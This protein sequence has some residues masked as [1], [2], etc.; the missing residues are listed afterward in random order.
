[1]TKLTSLLIGSGDS[2]LMENGKENY[3][4][5]SGGNQKTI[6]NLIPFSINLAIC[7]HNDSDHCKGFI[8]ILKSEKHTI[9][10]IWLLGIWATVIAFVKKCRYDTAFSRQLLDDIEFK[11]KRIDL[12]R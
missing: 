7:T 3:L 2:F 12:N 6:L 8:G 10:E 9:D 4:I 11:Q 1:M 5:D